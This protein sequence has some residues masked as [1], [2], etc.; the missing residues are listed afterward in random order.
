MT[1]FIVSTVLIMNGLLWFYI[2]IITL[3]EIK[4]D[5]TKWKTVAIRIEDF[6]LLKGICEKKYRKPASMISKL[7]HDYCVHMSKKE[8]VK[9]EVLKE[10]LSIDLP[11][12]KKEKK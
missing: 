4:M 3:Q 8:Q 5:L 12:N 11:D 9:L 1:K 7:I 6:Y 2:Y 10:M